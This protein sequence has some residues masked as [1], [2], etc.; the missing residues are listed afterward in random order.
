VF[1]KLQRDD[2]FIEC[3]RLEDVKV[4]GEEWRWVVAGVLAGT[5]HFGTSGVFA[6]GTQSE[7]DYFMQ[8]AVVI[9]S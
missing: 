8:L 2:Y 1:T 4:S 9:K 6:R 5:C 3:V 7:I